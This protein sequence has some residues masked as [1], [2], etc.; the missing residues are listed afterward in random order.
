[1]T[2]SRSSASMKSS[3]SIFQPLEGIPWPSFS[4]PVSRSS[5]TSIVAAGSRANV[6]MS[7][8]IVFNGSAFW[9]LVLG[10]VDCIR[11]ER[12]PSGGRLGYEGLYGTEPN[13]AGAEL[14]KLE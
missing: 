13:A 4:R 5:S 14:L 11:F 2:P 3:R 10:L 7:S 9:P 6:L 12:F 1:M 8:T